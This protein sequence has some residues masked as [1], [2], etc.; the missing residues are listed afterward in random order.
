ME[1]HEPVPAIRLDATIKVKEMP[2]LVVRPG[3]QKGYIR[4]SPGYQASQELNSGMLLRDPSGE[5]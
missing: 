4:R 5:K 1:V 3:A 2:K